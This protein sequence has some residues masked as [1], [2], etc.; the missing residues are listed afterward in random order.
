MIQTIKISFAFVCLILGCLTTI[1]AP[2]MLATKQ[3]W[4]NPTVTLSS[5]ALIIV[6]GVYCFSKVIKPLI[7]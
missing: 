4:L 5:F 6:T 2:D 7:F 1:F 3:V